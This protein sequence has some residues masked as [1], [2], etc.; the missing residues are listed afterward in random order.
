MAVECKKEYLQYF[1]YIIYIYFIL[2]EK[3]ED[4][5]MITFV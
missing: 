1:K 5:T 3:I 4:T 2:R